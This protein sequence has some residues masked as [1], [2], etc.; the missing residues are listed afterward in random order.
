[1]ATS[2][3]HGVQPTSASRGSRPGSTRSP[4]TSRAL[5]TLWL[6]ARS[7]MPRAQERLTVT[8][9]ERGARRSPPRPP[10]RRE[11][12]ASRSRAPSAARRAQRA[13]ADGEDVA[14]PEHAGGG[15]P[16]PR[17]ATWRIVAASISTASAPRSIQRRR[18]ALARVVEEVAAR[19]R[20][21]TGARRPP[22]AR[23]ARVGR[24]RAVRAERGA[25]AV[26][27]QH[28]LHGEQGAERELGIERPAGPD[29]DEP[30]APSAISS[31]HTIAALGPPMP[32]AWTVSG[33][34]SA[35]TPV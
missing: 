4:G 27:R 13:A 2:A 34:P 21:G 23:A 17:A 6:R 1:M 28:R 9:P 19:H 35:A 20:G 26:C 31:S 3:G 14:H 16:A 10:A 24:E 12:L 33:S 32:V 11:L 15:H 22:A 18:R 8:T 5:A 30:V 25:R 7:P 29:P